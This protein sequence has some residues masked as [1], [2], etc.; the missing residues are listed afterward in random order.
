MHEGFPRS[1]YLYDRLH[2]RV[3][4]TVTDSHSVKNA[5]SRTEMA[6]CSNIQSSDQYSF[7][8]VLLKNV[9][10]SAYGDQ[11]LCAGSWYGTLS[12]TC[13]PSRARGQR[14]DMSRVTTA[15]DVV[16]GTVVTQHLILMNEV[17]DKNGTGK[18]K[19]CTSYNE[20]R[21]RS[22]RCAMKSVGDIAQINARTR[23]AA[24]CT[25]RII[26]RCTMLVGELVGCWLVDALVDPYAVVPGARAR[27][28]RGAD[29][30]D[31]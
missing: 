9:R 23:G 8:A 27:G 24:R 28:Q 3:R 13:G 12:T 7:S 4:Y 14:S 1:S 2:S 11:N 29:M 22:L 10:R 31:Q 20:K 30:R 15:W 18:A 6:Q 5:H 25:V 21:S 16:A 26:T 17:T 19:S